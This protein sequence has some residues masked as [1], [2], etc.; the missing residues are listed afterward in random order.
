MFPAGALDDRAGKVPEGKSGR[1]VSFHFAN[2]TTVLLPEGE[3]G[4]PS[5]ED[6]LAGEIERPL[7]GHR[8]LRS[9]DLRKIPGVFDNNEI[10]DA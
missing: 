7:R 6:F 5:S 8:A 3:R 9:Q 10:T 4:S 1:G 2:G